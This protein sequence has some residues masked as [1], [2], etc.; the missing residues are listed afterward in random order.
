MVSNRQKKKRLVMRTFAM[1]F[2][3]ALFT[4]IAQAQNVY[5]HSGTQTVPGT[6]SLNF[7]DSGGP[8]SPD[9]WW[10]KWYSHNE[11]ATLTFKNGASPILV[12]F[13]QFTAYDGNTGANLGQ[14]ALRVND[15]HLYVYEGDKVD[16][17]KLIVDL[18]GTI[19]EP[20]SIMANGPIT[21]KFVSNASYREEGW[22]ASV[23]TASTYAVQQP[24]M[25]KETCDDVVVLLPTAPNATLYYTTDGSTPTT[26]STEYTAPFAIDLD[27]QTASVTVKAIAVVDTYTSAMASNTFTH[28]DQRP[29]PGVPQRDL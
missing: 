5:M 3:M 1:L 16:N 14:F 28:D 15:D 24:V 12:T 21:F 6:G 29:T 10:E 19:K 26:S 22:A 20:F 27:A 8:S 18:T 2:F 25:M 13:N 11:N 17:N 23:S 7:Y 9:F 4:Q